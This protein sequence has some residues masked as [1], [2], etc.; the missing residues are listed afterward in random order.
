MLTLIAVI[1][2]FIAHGIVGKHTAHGKKERE[3]DKK[4]EKK[5][6]KEAMSAESSRLL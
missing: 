4:K 1:I 3:I 2:T 6:G 5:N